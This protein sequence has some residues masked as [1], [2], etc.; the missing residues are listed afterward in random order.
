[1]RLFLG[2]P[3]PE[4]ITAE[5]SRISLRYQSPGD[6]LRWYQPE[7]W[8]ITLQFLGSVAP[9]Q[10]ASILPAMRALRHPLV[11]VA[12]DTL[13]F[14]DRAGVFFAQIALTPE[15]LSLQRRVQAANIPFGF[16][17]E[18][19]PYHPHITLARTKGRSGTRA[20]HTLQT[21]L[22]GHPYNLFATFTASEFVLYESIATPSGSRYE[23][24]DR[25][26]LG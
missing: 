21:Q 20:L 15:L 18:A 16:A 1:M 24:R 5:L 7:S 12:L 23:I 17:P 2:I 9:E 8:H 19:R 4:S 10:Y 11:P 14:F 13:G 6:N 26:P 22:Q 3:L 25:F